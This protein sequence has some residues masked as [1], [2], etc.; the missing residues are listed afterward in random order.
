MNLIKINFILFIL[1]ILCIYYIINYI[2]LYS[3]IFKILIYIIFI[4]SLYWSQ[5][6]LFISKY[7][8]V[9]KYKSTV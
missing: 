1:Y 6:F 7:Y 4:K 5:L 8:M 9:Y 3:F 2:M